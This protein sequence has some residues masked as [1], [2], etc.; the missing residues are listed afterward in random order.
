MVICTSPANEEEDVIFDK[1]NTQIDAIRRLPVYRIREHG[2]CI[3]QGDSNSVLTLYRAGN[4]GQRGGLMDL[5]R[6]PHGK[7]P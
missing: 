2:F 1:P 6:R 4:V 7:A 5:H 3:S